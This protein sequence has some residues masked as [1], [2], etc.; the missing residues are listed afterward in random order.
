M[1]QR[2]ILIVDDPLQIKQLRAA[3]ERPIVHDRD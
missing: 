3:C 1:T 2:R